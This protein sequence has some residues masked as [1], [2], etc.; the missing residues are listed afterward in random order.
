MLCP[1]HLPQLIHLLFASSAFSP[2]EQKI[3]KSR[4]MQQSAS[5][6]SGPSVSRQSGRLTSARQPTRGGIQKRNATPSRVDKDGDLVMDAAGARV[7][8][9][10]RV[11]GGGRGSAIRGSAQTRRQNTPDSLSSRIST[12]PARTGIDT[13]AIQKAVLRGMGSNE[14]LPRAPR[15]ALKGVRA[16]ENTRE[17]KDGLN[18][19]SVRGLKESKAA[20]NKDGGVS[21]LIAFLERKATNPDAPARDAVKIKKVCL[22]SQ[23]AGHQQQRCRPLRCLS[24]L[25]SFQSQSTERRPRYA[26]TAPG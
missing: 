20:S 18:K 26:A 9:G 25:L 5:T 24:G 1:R 6:P 10:G 13:S 12:R 21:D 8:G 14:T 4:N 17:V 22:T 19:I 15:A 3:S 7:R 23:L 16:R 2:T 11:S